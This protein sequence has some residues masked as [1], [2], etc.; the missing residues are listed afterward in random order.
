[1]GDSSSTHWLTVKNWLGKYAM[2]WYY[3]CLGQ[4]TIPKLNMFSENLCRYKTNIFGMKN[5]QKSAI[6]VTYYHK[7]NRLGWVEF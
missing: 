5:H 1:M 4:H 6:R 3:G 7:N 2:K